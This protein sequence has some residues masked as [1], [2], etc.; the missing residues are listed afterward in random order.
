MCIRSYHH[1]RA[2][3]EQRMADAADSAV[4]RI[5]HTKLAV[6]HRSLKA[7]GAL[8]AKGEAPLPVAVGS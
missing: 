3:T 4:A 7:D 6:L 2:L 1:R 8:G 5:C